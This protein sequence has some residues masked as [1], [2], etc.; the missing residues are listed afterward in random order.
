MKQ[1]TIPSAL[2][3][4]HLTT[5]LEIAS[6]LENTLEAKDIT[7]RLVE[8]VMI[9]KKLADSIEELSSL[10]PFKQFE[11]DSTVPELLT[12]LGSSQRFFPA[13]QQKVA[14]RA[15]QLVDSIRS[16]VSRL[17][18]SYLNKFKT[19]SLSFSD[20]SDTT[21]LPVNLVP[22]TNSELQKDQDKLGHVA[23]EINPTAGLI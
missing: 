8:S 11:Q 19:K 13:I 17:L 2:I 15:N 18:A 7:S 9:I 1:K 14:T 12:G 16:L 10:V 22:I 4:I 3:N 23:I 6:H 5:A 20:G 21:P